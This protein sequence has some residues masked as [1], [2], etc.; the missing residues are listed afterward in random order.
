MARESMSYDEVPYVGRIHFQSHVDTLATISALFGMSPANPEACRVLEIGCADGSNII[1]MAYH[2]RGS[3]FVG[4]DGSAPQI[5]CGQE[6]VDELGM[7]NIALHAVDLRDVD[8]SFGDFD[9][10]IAH[11]I[12]SWIAD[13]A[14]HA[15]MALCRERLK[16]DGVAYI[17]YNVYPGWHHYEQLRGMMRF[18]SRGMSSI[19]EEIQQARAIVRFVG[20][21]IIDTGSPR[22]EFFKSVMPDILQMNDDYVYHEY[23]ELNNK[24]MYFYEFVGLAGQHNLQYLGESMFHSMMSSNYPEKV[25]ATLEEISNN[26]L[27]LEQY[28]DFLRNRRFRCT[29]LCNREIE[30][31]RGV[32]LSPLRLMKAAFWFDPED[33]DHDPT[34]H[35]PLSFS[36]PDDAET[37][38]V[39]NLPLHKTALLHLAKT[40]PAAVAF[41]DLVS[42]CCTVLDIPPTDEVATDLAELIMQLYTQSFIELHTVQPPMINHVEERPRATRL[43]R[44]QARHCRVL[45]SQKHRMVQLSD[46]QTRE[47]VARLD[48][49]HTVEDIVEELLP[50][51]DEHTLARLDDP[52]VALTANVKLILAR[53]A[54]E[55]VLVPEGAE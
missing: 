18:H 20:D 31:K 35:G 39:V 37:S 38:A 46:P 40:W 30:L 36:S 42:H 54:A 24:P 34:Q 45:S 49:N 53:M 6:I 11:G 43:A 51:V 17:S 41:T 48:G 26:I 21:S 10:I 3:T 23:L 27:E 19:K 50:L 1:T 9:Y 29:L 22:A 8:A 33:P 28:M 25:A 7:D 4:V 2:L 5:A 47:V 16:P 14:R 55:G 15:L 13:D 12:F 52:V 32:E 44:Y